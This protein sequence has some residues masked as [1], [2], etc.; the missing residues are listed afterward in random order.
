MG[1]AD[2]RIDVLNYHADFV[3]FMDG[4]MVSDFITFPYFIENPDGEAI[5]DFELVATKKPYDDDELDYEPGNEDVIFCVVRN[6]KPLEGDYTSRPPQ[7][8]YLD[9]KC[10]LSLAD[11]KDTKLHAECNFP[12]MTFYTAEDAADFFA[13]LNYGYLLEQKRQTLDKMVLDFFKEETSPQDPPCFSGINADFIRELKEVC[14]GLN[15]DASLFFKKNEATSPHLKDDLH[16]LV[17]RS[18]HNPD[19]YYLAGCYGINHDSA[20]P[21]PAFNAMAIHEW[22]GFTVPYI[23]IDKLPIEDETAIGPLSFDKIIELG[24][25]MD[26]AYCVSVEE[27]IPASRKIAFIKNPNAN[28]VLVYLPR[29]SLG[30]SRQFITA[31][32]D[33]FAPT[34]TPTST[35]TASVI[36]FPTRQ[37]L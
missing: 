18:A 28:D 29:H 8:F 16:L 4:K 22:L 23:D 19:E 20:E 17:T 24:A 21:T 1:N 37:P 9:P 31:T 5:I 12:L 25:L 14:S 32:A 11:L 33:S 2:R 35:T 26:A 36:P 30:A 3:A 34:T 6:S 27:H 7:P 13:L 10:L 15:E